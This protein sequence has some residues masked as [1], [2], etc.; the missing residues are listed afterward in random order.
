MFKKVVVN[1][2]SL[3]VFEEI[4]GIRYSVGFINH[5]HYVT[6]Y[7]IESIHNRKLIKDIKA[8]IKD[9]HKIHTTIKVVY[10]ESYLN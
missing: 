1:D 4:L 6:I 10:A 7:P 5:V 8:K 2:V 3:T 9:K